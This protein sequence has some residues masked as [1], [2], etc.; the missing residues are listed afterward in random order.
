MH[1]QI[2]LCLLQP[3]RTI[4]YH[5]LFRIP[6]TEPPT[7]QRL[8]T[9]L[10]NAHFQLH[11]TQINH[12]VVQLRRLNGFLKCI[13]NFIIKCIDRACSS[14]AT[15]RFRW[16]RNPIQS[17]LGQSHFIKHVRCQVRGA[18]AWASTSSADPNLGFF[19]QRRTT[20]QLPIDVGEIPMQLMFHF[21]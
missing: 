2:A 11:Y 1:G 20:T 21:L 4:P 6:P 10:V 9:Y 12:C 15:S 14:Q 19:T 8:V 16:A 13:I 3:P 7:E 18:W 17:W 5:A